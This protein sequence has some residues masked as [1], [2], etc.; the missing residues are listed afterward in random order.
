MKSIPDP[1]VV[2]CRAMP[3]FA[4]L[5]L[6]GA[7]PA[8]FPRRPA[9]S[10]SLKAGQGAGGTPGSGVLCMDLHSSARVDKTHSVPLAPQE[11]PV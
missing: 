8:A 11:V 9:P 2:L 7:E 4:Q 10:I 3:S 1:A 5:P 6:A